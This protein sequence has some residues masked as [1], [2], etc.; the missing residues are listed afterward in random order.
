MNATVHLASDEHVIDLGPVFVL[1]FGQ[2]YTK[3][4]PVN[5]TP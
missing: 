4:L 5:D 3:P 1:D 2:N